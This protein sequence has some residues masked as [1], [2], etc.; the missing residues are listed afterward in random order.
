MK[1]GELIFLDVKYHTV[2]HKNKLFSIRQER[3]RPGYFTVNSESVVSNF[4]ISLGTADSHG[5]SFLSKMVRGFRT[6][7]VALYFR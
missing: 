1:V 7:R 2:L 4:A 6:V 5:A 3:F